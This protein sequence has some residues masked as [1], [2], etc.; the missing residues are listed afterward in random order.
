MTDRKSSPS[1][2]KAQAL[3]IKEAWTNMGPTSTYGDITLTDYTAAITALETTE[4]HI[5]NLE[6]QLAG[7]RNACQDQRYNLWLLVKRVRDGAKSKY[8]DDSDAYK[9]FGGTR[10]SDRKLRGAKKP[11]EPP[12][13]S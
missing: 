9:R 13:H 3:K 2:T 7:A 5:K 10:M 8:G 11:T 6:D 12:A 4:A 1:D